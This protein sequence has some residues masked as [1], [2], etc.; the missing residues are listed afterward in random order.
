MN[1]YLPIKFLK[2]IDF[3]GQSFGIFKFKRVAHIIG[4]VYT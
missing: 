1:I 2:F 4:S 3:L